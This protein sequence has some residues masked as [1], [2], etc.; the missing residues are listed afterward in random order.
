MPER[1]SQKRGRCG[2]KIT[3]LCVVVAATAIISLTTTSQGFWAKP[4]KAADGSL[5]LLNWEVG[6]PGK[7]GVSRAVCT[8]FLLNS[9]RARGSTAYTNSTCSSQKVGAAAL[10]TQRLIPLRL[11]IQATKVQVHS[12]A[13]PSK[14]LPK[15]SARPEKPSSAQ[16]SSGTVCL[17]IL[18]EEK[19]WKPA[20][21]M[22]QVWRATVIETYSHTTQIVLGIQELLTD[23]NASD[24]AQVEAYT[25]FK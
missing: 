19:G 16:L 5:N 9:C 17:S 8:A 2:G 7:S 12:T 14:C 4:T 10:K 13:I 18:D 20:I 15:V 25:M 3:L 6:I 21:T 24:P 1:D 23:P 11:P 22:K